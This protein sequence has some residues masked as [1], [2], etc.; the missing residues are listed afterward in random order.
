[1]RKTLAALLALLTLTFFGACSSSGG[2]DDDA[3]GSTT[4]EQEGGDE[5]TTTEDEETTTTEDDGGE[6]GTVDV[7]EWAGEFCG[8]FDTWMTAV[9]DAGTNV[10]DSMGDSTDLESAKTAVVGLFET[11]SSETE[12]LIGAIEDG[13]APDIEDGE[14]LVDDLVGKFTEFNDSI[15]SAQAEAE[16]LDT[17]DPAAFATDVQSV[18]S[19]FQTEVTEVG[20]SFSELDS[21]YPSEELND[22]LTSSCNL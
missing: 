4:T 7:D 12:T 17:A 10:A 15:E 11:I 14:A 2:N 5:T 18:V 16:G 9:Q 1:M 20:N 6:G 13:G 21:K 22:A 3:S 19:T 8:N